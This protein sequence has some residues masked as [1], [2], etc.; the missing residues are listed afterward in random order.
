MNNASILQLLLDQLRILWLYLQR[1]SVQAQLLALVVTFVITAVLTHVL[2]WVVRRFLV[3][4][5]VAYV[6]AD[7]SPEEDPIEPEEVMT[8]VNEEAGVIEPVAP[9]PPAPA[10]TPVA[11]PTH[12]SRFG[13]LR[14]WVYAIQPLF[15]PIISLILLQGLIPLMQARNQPIGLIIATQLLLTL[16]LVYSTIVT[17]LYSRLLAKQARFYDHFLVLP[18]FILIV[19]NLILYSL[20]IRDLI[21][22]LPL[23][24]L[25]GVD[26][27]IDRG[28]N[29]VLIIYYAFILSRL[30][31]DVLNYIIPHRT[32]MD[33]DVQ[34]SVVKL[35]RNLTIAIGILAAL[36]SLG[37]SFTALA[38]IA[39]GLSVGIGSGLDNIASNLASGLLLWSDDT[40]RI[41]DV[42]TINGEMGI[43]EKMGVRATIVRTFDN[44]ELIVP[45]QDFMTQVVTAF[46]KSNRIVRATIN[47]GVG[48]G[49][50]VELVE[51]ILYETARKHELVNTEPAP[52]VFFD[53]FGDSSLDFRLL[54]WVD[55][56]LLLA[57]VRSQ[58]HYHILARFRA[59]GIEIPFPKRDVYLDVQNWPESLARGSS[60]SANDK[61]E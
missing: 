11:D 26:I 50:N 43:V 37:F 45:N 23:P 53:G 27:T 22:E 34:S 14:R 12:T 36:G 44:V 4:D 3:P 8:V 19:F 35:A 58:L 7:D 31:Q 47:V 48:Y 42:I 20:S 24:N 28:L 16:F 5:V 2:R 38:F 54:V 56:P 40:V 33:K 32:K 49:S 17:L 1:P 60:G 57:R 21:F 41:G 29:F 61:P 55:D 46:T 39:G 13:H 52:V 18:T 30:I 6:E 9:L 59:E 51:T 25:F 15:F 10:P